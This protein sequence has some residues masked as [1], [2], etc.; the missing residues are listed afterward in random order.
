MVRK[1]SAVFYSVLIIF[2]FTIS[3]AGCGESKAAAFS[4]FTPEGDGDSA[5]EL[6]PSEDRKNAII[7]PKDPITLTFIGDIMAHNN[8]FNMPDYNDIYKDIKELF[9]KDDLTFGNLEFPICE[10][11]PMST[12]PMFN[13]HPPYVEAAINAGFEVFSCANNHTTDK[14]PEGVKKTYTAMK[15]FETDYGIYFSGIRNDTEKPFRP[16]YILYNRWKI[17]FFAATE[18]LNTYWGSDYANVVDYHDEEVLASFLELLERE[19]KD[20]DLFILSFHGDKEYGLLPGRKKIEFFEKCLLSGVD[21]IWAHHPH[22]LQPWSLEKSASG[23][24]LVLY[25]TGNFISGQ[26]HFLDPKTS[27]GANPY[28]GES[29]VFQV[30][31]RDADDKPV[32]QA[33]STVPIANYKHPTK[34]M[35]VRKHDRLLSAPDVPEVWRRFYARRLPETA[36][37]SANYTI[38]NILP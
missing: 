2:T 13:V 23:D 35:V 38:P 14:G 1:V 27:S 20:F 5:A 19:T 37:L 3:L 30:H 36:V 9:L 18:H 31:L 25:S 21:I 11:L 24:K 6:G 26:T 22:V 32:I 8:N 15:E 16:E 28:T 33:V 10:D 7:P 34:G 17:G 12:F 4:Q 29:A